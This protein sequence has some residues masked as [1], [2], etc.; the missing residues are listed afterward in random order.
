MGAGLVADNNAPG[1]NITGTSDAIDTDAIFDLMLAANPDTVKV[2]LLYDKSQASSLASIEAA[3]AY[4]DENG[5]EYVEKTGTTSA[6]VQAAADALVAE[7]VNAVFTP[8]DNTIMTAELAIFEKFTEAGIPHYTGA[9]S[10]ALNGAFCGY[11]VNYE[12]LGTKTADMVVEVLVNGT[13]PAAT[14]VQTLERGIV[15]VNTETA[16]AVGLDYSMF[17][18]MCSELVEVVTAEDFE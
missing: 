13:D 16:E 6:E 4:C 8:Q 14:P 9:D 18:D 2:G 11:G 10:F 17:V 3:K 5:I 7:G 15:T 1:A 12:D